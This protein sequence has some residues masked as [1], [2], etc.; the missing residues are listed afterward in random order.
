MRKTPASSPVP[1]L[2]TDGDD[3]GIAVDRLESAAQSHDGHRNASQVP[4]TEPCAVDAATL[5]QELAA[6]KDDYLRLAADF[7]NFKKRTRRDS[8]RQA[9]AEK[10]AFIAD[11]LP[12]VDNLERALASGQSSSCEQLHQGVEMTWQQ[13]GQLLNRHGIEAVEDVGRPFDPHRHEAVS[14]RHDPRQPDH[15]VLEVIQ[16]G[17]CRDDKVFRPAKVIVNDLSHSPG[18]RHAG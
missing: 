18:A 4:Q 13:L 7:D 17:Y 1:L 2:T 14:V 15:I 16:R 5:Q 9:T 12:A 3:V 10:D 6:Q 11:L 8:E